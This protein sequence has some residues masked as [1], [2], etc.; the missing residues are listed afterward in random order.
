MYYFYDII[1]G[2]KLYNDFYGY[3]INPIDPTLFERFKYLHTEEMQKEIHII[4]FREQTLIGDAAL[5]VNPF[6]ENIFW[7]KHVIVDSE[8]RNKRIS[9]NLINIAFE[10]SQKNNMNFF[11]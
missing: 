5:Q 6:D 7:L 2:K 4:A 1:S 3:G 8:H 10:H 9:K 11:F